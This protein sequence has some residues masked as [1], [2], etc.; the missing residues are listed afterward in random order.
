MRNYYKTECLKRAIKLADEGDYDSL[1]YSSLEL[2]QCIESIIY[3]KLESY[4]KYVPDVV[5]KKWQPNHALKTLLYFEPDAEQSMKI[6]IAPES[7]VGVTSGPF[8]YIGEHKAL[9]VEWLNK[10]WLLAE[11]SG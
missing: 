9:T 1:I 10:N 2:R 3:E 4:K 8:Q 7:P 6:A 11:L 5:F